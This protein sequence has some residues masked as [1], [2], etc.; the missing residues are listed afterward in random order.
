MKKEFL[1]FFSIIIFFALIQMMNFLLSPNITSFNYFD[2][3]IFTYGPFPLWILILGSYFGILLIRFLIIKPIEWMLSSKNEKDIDFVHT[4]HAQ[5]NAKIKTYAYVLFF[6]I[7]LFFTSTIYWAYWAEI[8]ELARGEGKVIP[9]AKIQTI[10][11]LDGGVISEILVKEGSIVKKGQA[12]MKI[13]TTRFE[14]SLSENKNLLE[15][16]IA[17]KI[18]LEA[19]ID[20]DIDK[21]MPILEFDNKQL[22]SYPEIIEIQKNLFKIRYEELKSVMNTLKL[23]MQQ[24]RQEL[25]EL[26]SK[27]SQLYR[28][29][30]FIKEEMATIEKLVSRKAKSNIELIAIKRK[31]NDLQGEYN[32]VRLSIPRSEL[33]IKES[34]SKLVE[35]IK[36]FK[37]EAT[38][39]LQE[40]NSE[41]NTYESKLVSEQDKLDKTIIVSPVD[42]IIKLIYSNTIG[43]V[44]RSGVDLIEIVPNSE[45]LLVEAKIDPKDI[46]FINP[47]QKVVIKISAYDFSIYGALDG[48][49]R[50]I[51]ADTIKD[52][53][54]KE[55]KSFYKIIVET[56]KT[57]LEKNGEEFPIIPGMIANIEIITG[58]KTI[59]DFILKPI[60]K[61]KDGA[62]HER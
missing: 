31:Y 40:I 33:S 27:Q 42:G 17:T 44:V 29:L 23:Q 6:I 62:L 51:S 25:L 22:K 11:S 54:S 14:A 49:I 12:L 2:I 3:M 57:Y 13:D 30:Q 53:E 47:T 10:Q 18:R 55:G 39:T 15:S 61:T 58:K 60:L 20:L 19:E 59:L 26:K 36:N 7:S 28:S 35:K 56:N 43:G 21:P 46:A 16:L 5:A 38:H 50:E 4:L 34:E 45:V 1:L 8:D 48:K 24:K 32:A 52:E 37:S 41:I 9:T